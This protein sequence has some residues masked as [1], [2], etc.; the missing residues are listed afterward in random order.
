M[1]HID[2]ARIA[3]AMGGEVVGG[4]AKF[5]TPGHGKTDRGSWA[6]ILSGAPDGLLVHSANGGDPLAI[7]DQLRVKGLLPERQPSAGRCDIASWEYTDANG[8]VLYRKVRSE[9]KTFRFEHPDGKGGWK[10]GRG[11][12]PTPYR[13]PELIAAP[14][15]ATI[16]MVEGEKQA[17]K[18]TS[19]GLVATSLKDWR[20]EFGEHVAGRRVV[21]LPDN[22]G[23]G[24]KQAADTRERLISAGISTIV[25]VTLP[26][27][28]AKGDVMDWKGDRAALE[29]LTVEAFAKPSEALTGLSVLDW[30]AL[31]NEVLPPREWTLAGMIPHGEVTLLSGPGGA[32]KSYAGQQLATCLAAGR[33]FLGV[34]TR[35]G[36]TLYVTAED[37]IRELRFRQSKICGHLGIALLDIAD[38]L[39]VV[40]LRGGEGNELCLFDFDGRIRSTPT[41][42]KLV[43]TIE[44]TGASLVVLDNVAHLFTGNENDRGQVT[45]FANLLNRLALRGV[46][47]VLV[48]HPNKSGDSYSGST[49]WLNAVRS[50]LTLD[51]QR[52]DDGSI[53]DRDA[54]ILSVG[55]KSNYGPADT[56]IEFR[57]HDHA[58]LR[59]ADM[60]AGFAERM[61]L[62]TRATSENTCFLYCLDKA[63]K[64]KRAVSHN[65]GSNYA[66]KVFAGMPEARGMK[67]AAFAA[68]MERLISLGNIVLDEQLW[69]GPNRV[70][71]QGIKRAQTAPTPRTD[72]LHEAAPA[73][74]QKPHAPTPLYTTYKPG[75][76]LEAAPPV[77]KGGEGAGRYRVVFP[78]VDDADDP[79]NSMFDV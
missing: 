2:L 34:E 9:P 63:T 70:M 52:D 42:D 10:A 67:Q 5:P 26:G 40:T 20:R 66:P 12:N 45:R 38:R 48:A 59:D 16:Y 55:E 31:A 15:G 29:A 35:P 57:W 36:V 19:W 7:K 17:D 1:P 25:T 41:F 58:L 68:A 13:L 50:H 28:P 18:L 74:A 8:A 65:V 76:P 51:Y 64:D 24:R 53:P 77:T 11:C 71:K 54:R 69:R 44:R 4:V 43:A 60:E 47:V 14:A 56:A 75:G 46:A 32:G 79:A 62:T 72:P 37:D 23:E 21:I 73:H 6:S 78:E 49:A 39:H 3:A 22:D 30:H 27:L 33:P 61:A